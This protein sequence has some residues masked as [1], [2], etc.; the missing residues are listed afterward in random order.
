MRE[1]IPDIDLDGDYFQFLKWLPNHMFE[2]DEN[3]FIFMGRR[4]V[5]SISEMKTWTL[6]QA[7]QC[8][9]MKAFI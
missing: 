3:T 1:E 9:K 7:F 6:K 8:Y 4:E 2:L 5:L